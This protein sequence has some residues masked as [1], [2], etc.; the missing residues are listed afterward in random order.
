MLPGEAED[1]VHERGRAVELLSFGDAECLDLSA[2]AL[3]D[4][5]HRGLPRLTGKL[6]ANPRVRVD[7]VE[8]P[9]G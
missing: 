6:R 8:H 4:V 2:D 1:V 9:Q 3:E 7:R 5:H